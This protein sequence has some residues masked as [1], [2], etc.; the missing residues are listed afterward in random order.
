MG[1]APYGNPRRFDLS[2]LVRR[3]ADDIRVN[4]RLIN[5]IGRRRHRR[6]A[7]H[8]ISATRS[9]VGSDPVRAGDDIDEP[10][11]HYAAAAQKLLE[12]AALELI[13]RYVGDI[14]RETGRLCF[15]GGVALNVKLN[16]RL[17]QWP[18]LESLFVQPAAGDA[19]TS[20]GAA[21]MRRRPRRARAE[22]GA[23]LSRAVFQQRRVHRRVSR[24]SAA[25][26][27]VTPRRCTSR[28]RRRSSRTDIRSPGFRA[29]WSSGRGHSATAAS[30]AIPSRAG[31]AERINAQI[32]YRER[33]RPFCP[34]M[35]DT[36]ARD[37]LQSVHPAQ[38]MTISFAVA[39]EWQRAFPEVVHEDGTARAQ[40]VSEADQSAFPSADSRARAAHGECRRAQHVDEPARRAD[41]LHAGRRA[42]SVLRIGSAVT[43]SWKTCCSPKD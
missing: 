18:H 39:P 9:S 33:W 1:M 8:T 19:G 22:I 11:I 40:V 20:V 37:V 31:M 3:G 36:V 25:T 12:D 29:A 23:R 34:S 26:V 38:Y 30:W 24:S 6:T 32:K 5:V 28:K 21:S 42:G 10:Y 41:R 14:V 16:Q 4:T 13:D 2:R 27:L 35:L 7:G 15:A 17:L 43:S